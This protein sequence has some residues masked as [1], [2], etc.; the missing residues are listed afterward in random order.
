MCFLIV[1]ILNHKKK[2]YNRRKCVVQGGHCMARTSDA[3]IQKYTKMDIAQL[4]D[5]IIF[6][7]DMING[8]VKEGALHD[9]AI[10]KTIQ[11]ICDLLDKEVGR[12]IFV[13]DAH[14]PKTREFLSYPSHC[15]IGTRESEV[16][17]ELYPYVH[18]LFHKNSTN[19]FTSVDFQQFLKERMPM[20]Q[21]IVICGCCSDIC[22]MQFAL[23]LNA[24][25]NEHNET[26]KRVIIPMDCIDTYH[27]DD[28][29]DAVEWNEFSIRNMEA[30]GIQVVAGFKGENC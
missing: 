29:H 3:F 28:V 8:F 14:P 23:C 10:S 30:N 2:V 1:F 27:I 7:V 11:P 6:V 21:D 24:W 26:K 19:T 15:V 16:V 22:I 17:E 13:A 20:Y 18:E 5:P 25:L 12:G 9:E 4:K